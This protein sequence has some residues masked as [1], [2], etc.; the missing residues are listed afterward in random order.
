MS[1]K[2]DNIHAHH[3]ERMRK[4]IAKNGLDSL[5][6]HEVLEYL[7]YPF[8]PRKDTNPIAHT[9]LDIAGGTLEG[10]FNS[11]V[12][13]LMNVPNMTYSAS[14]F[15]A[16]LSQLINRCNMQKLSDKVYLRNTEDAI[17]YFKALFAEELEEYFYMAL[18]APDGRLVDTCK[19]SSY[20]DSNQ[21]KLDIKRFILKTAST[22]ASHYFL[23]HNHPS[24]NPN[25]SLTDF[26]FTKWL[27]SLSKSLE[28]ELVDYIIVSRN[29]CFS[30]NRCGALA[31]YAD[32]FKKFCR[33]IPI[34]DKYK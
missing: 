20:G 22:Q 18:V 5:Q 16:N 33:Y 34:Q 3:R 13:M 27:V 1:N 26:E 29:G 25:P 7:L 14:L 12:E 31:D 6:D 10:V 8:I 4:R 9:L 21:C 28:T 15:L 17:K 32:E 2:S 23:A 11:P 24:G 30:F 19:I